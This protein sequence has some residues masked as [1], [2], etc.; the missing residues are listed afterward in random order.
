MTRRGESSNASTAEEAYNAY[1]SNLEPFPKR[2]LAL[3]SMIR[4]SWSAAVITR[5]ERGHSRRMLARMQAV[6]A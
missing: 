4:S 1:R 6:W 3:G 5:R 2:Q